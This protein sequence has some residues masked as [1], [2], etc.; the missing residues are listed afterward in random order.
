MGKLNGSFYGTG[1]NLVTEGQGGVPNDK[2]EVA[3]HI[4][5]H[6]IFSKLLMGQPVPA[7]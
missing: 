7:H 5:V 1:G 6:N 4:Y 3:M 2:R